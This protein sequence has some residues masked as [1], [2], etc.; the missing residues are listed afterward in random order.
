MKTKRL[1]EFGLS[2]SLSMSS[3]LVVAVPKV[4]ASPLDLSNGFV[5]IITNPKITMVA[6]LLASGV[7]LVIAR[8]YN[9]VNAR[10]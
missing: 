3:L 1:A 2:L 10:R 9:H 8:R 6:T 4:H 5:S 7:L